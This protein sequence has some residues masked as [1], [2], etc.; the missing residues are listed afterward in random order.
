MLLIFGAGGHG[1]VLAETAF[2]TGQWQNIVFADQSYP[3][4]T[5]HHGFPIVGSA[6]TLDQLKRQ[7]HSAAVAIGNNETRLEFIHRLQHAGFE[8]PTIYHPTAWISN[9]AILGAGS[10]VFAGS[11]IQASCKL[12]LGCIVNTAASIDHDCDLGDG[13][14]ISPGA[15][16]AGGVSIGV[17]SWIGIGASIISGVRVASGAIVGAGSVVTQ[18]V[19][20]NTTVAGVPACTIPKS[21][22]K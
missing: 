22:I 5:E 6:D 19:P 7:Y 4:K 15:H 8:L 3:E 9:S 14:H 16:I 13:V 11:I 12:G 20:E 17:K 10:A 1:K 18:N 21:T 2:A